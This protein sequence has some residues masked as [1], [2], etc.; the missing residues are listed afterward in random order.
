MFVYIYQY[1]FNDSSDF[2][3]LI[4]FEILPKPKELITAS[5]TVT[6]D[7]YANNRYDYEPIIKKVLAS[8]YMNYP[9]YLIIET[10]SKEIVE[11]VLLENQLNYLLLLEKPN[12][13]VFKVVI[14]DEKDL[15]AMLPT[16]YTSG[17][18]S[19]FNLMTEFDEIVCLN[20]NQIRIDLSKD[21]AS[22]SLC[23]LY[24]LQELCFLGYEEPQD[25]AFI[26]N[27]FLQGS[28]IVDDLEI[29]L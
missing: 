2:E 28:V 20:D 26:K 10:Y 7:S 12:T 1:K 8:S 19:L 13:V 23:F 29:E 22:K 24:D 11:N 14:E 27:N 17:M 21:P 18:D 9:F 4:P 25:K 6:Q 15:L 5:S 3:S 16:L